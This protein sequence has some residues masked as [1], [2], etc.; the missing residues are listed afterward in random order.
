VHLKDAFGSLEVRELDWTKP[1][2][3]EGF[4]RHYDYVIG[5]DCVRGWPDSRMAALERFPD[6]TR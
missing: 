4:A 2:Q 1:E 3:L 6:L 5:T